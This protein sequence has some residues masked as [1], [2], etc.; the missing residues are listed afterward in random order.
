MSL[1]LYENVLYIYFLIC[2]ISNIC[3]F[4]QVDLEIHLIIFSFKMEEW[5]I[6]KVGHV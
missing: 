4:F 2:D 6:Q 5:L 1:E 3:K